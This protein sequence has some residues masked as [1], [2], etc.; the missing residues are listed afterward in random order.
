MSSVKQQIVDRLTQALSPDRLAVTDDS[1]LHA[2]HSEQA[3]A[4]ES[5]FTVEIVSDAFTGQ[6]RVQRHRLVNQALGD[7]MKAQVH[8]LAIKAK[9]PAEAG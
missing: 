7:L 2:G 1:A 8:A 6:T 3:R 4:G 9:A 5:H